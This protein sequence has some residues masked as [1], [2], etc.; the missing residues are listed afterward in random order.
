VLIHIAKVNG[1]LWSGEAREL[2]APGVEGEV[3]ILKD[4]VPLV[5]NLK[6]GRLIVR[7]ETGD[8]FTHDVERGVLEVTGKSATVLL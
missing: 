5:T 2:T 1:I 7:D 3:T 4:H 8:V 6:Q